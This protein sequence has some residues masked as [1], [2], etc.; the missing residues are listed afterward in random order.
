[1]FEILLNEAMRIEQE[2]ALGARLYQRT[3]DRMGYANGYKPK[4]V[5]TLM[6]KISVNV[7]Q[8]RGG[9][10]FYPSVRAGWHYP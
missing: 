1:V 5:D 9:V 4:A 2:Q 10:E 8:V 3:D 6:G 7:P